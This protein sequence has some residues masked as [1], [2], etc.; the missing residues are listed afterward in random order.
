M[1]KMKSNKSVR[2]RFKLTGTGKLLRTCPG[3]R[4]K[5]TKKSSQAKRNLSKR[6]VMDESQVKM[7]KRMML[8]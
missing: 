7:Y 2:S 3:K 4:H 6:P 8:A 5:L 1:P